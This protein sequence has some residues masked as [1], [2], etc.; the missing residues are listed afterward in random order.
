MPSLGL[1]ALPLHALPWRGRPLLAHAP[2]EY[3]LDLPPGAA[4]APRPGRA[5]VVGDPAGDLDAAR[6]EAERVTAG[7]RTRGLEVDAWIGRRPA[8]RSAPRS[9][10][11][12]TSTSPDTARSRASS[13]G[14]ARSAW[15][16]NTTLTIA[17]ILALRQV[18]RTALLLSCSAGVTRPDPRARGISL[19]GAF[20]PAGSQAVVAPTTVIASVVARHFAEAL[21]AEKAPT[22]ELSAIYRSAMLRLFAAQELTVSWQ[23]LRVW[24]P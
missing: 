3:S 13:G 17:D 6:V 16:R 23:A 8:R 1:Q 11:L 5:V 7:L 14:R 9:R 24:V 4:P 19:A 2:V 21:L 20:L 10:E 15:P 12:S 18:P 22:S